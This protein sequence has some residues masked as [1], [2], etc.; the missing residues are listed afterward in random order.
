M[1]NKK[2]NMQ[3]V[4]NNLNN[5]K[6]ELLS[7]LNNIGNFININNENFDNDK[8]V[9]LK[10]KINNQRYIVENYIIPEI[11]EDI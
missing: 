5:A 2:Y 9:N 6:N 7:A 8:I 1:E 3:M 11:T 4:S 10:N